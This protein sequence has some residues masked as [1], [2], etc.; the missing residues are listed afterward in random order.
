M[1][2][3]QHFPSEERLSNHKPECIKLNGVQAVKLPREGIE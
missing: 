3:I 1:N 2:C